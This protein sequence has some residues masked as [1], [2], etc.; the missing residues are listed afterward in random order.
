MWYIRKWAPGI[1]AQKPPPEVPIW[2]KFIELT[3]EYVS[4]RVLMR[5]ASKLG[6]PLWI[7]Q[8]TRLGQR[9]GYPKVLVEMTVDEE[10]PNELKLVPN[11]NPAMFVQLKYCNMP[12]ICQKCH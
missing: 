2:V 3:L 1:R 5:L 7:D 4:G 11:R 12:A 10:F 6:K 8:S 9:L